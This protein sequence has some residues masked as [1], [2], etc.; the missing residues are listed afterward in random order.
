MRSGDIIKLYDVVG[1][2]AAVTIVDTSLASAIPGFV[3][4]GTLAI[5]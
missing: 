3:T 5:R 1:V 2:G 4:P